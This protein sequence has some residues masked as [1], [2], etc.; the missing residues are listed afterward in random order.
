MYSGFEC[1]LTPIPIGWIQLRRI[2]KIGRTATIQILLTHAIM[3]VMRV[4]QAGVQ[5]CVDALDRRIAV[6]C[7]GEP[8][9]GVLVG[10]DV[11][12]RFVDGHRFQVGPLGVEARYNLPCSQAILNFNIKAVRGGLVC[13][14]RLRT[15]IPEILQNLGL[16]DDRLVALLRLRWSVIARDIG[17]GNL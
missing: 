3:T 9:S 15:A 1:I 12:D 10:C 16:I 2:L 6:D 17:L 8:R 4:A 5:R 14:R 7:R 13:I 11:S